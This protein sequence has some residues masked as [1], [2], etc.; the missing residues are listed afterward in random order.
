M[1]AYID[2]EQQIQNYYYRFPKRFNTDLS[3]VK[4]YGTGTN[5]V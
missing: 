1:Y 2:G 3:E 5:E 4:L